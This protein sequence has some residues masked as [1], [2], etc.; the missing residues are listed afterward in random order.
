MWWDIGV[1]S[2]G[3]MTDAVR[4]AHEHHSYKLGGDVWMN[5]CIVDLLQVP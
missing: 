1:R 4:A 3:R 2:H 5:M